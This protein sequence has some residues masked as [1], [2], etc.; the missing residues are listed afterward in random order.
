MFVSSESCVLMIGYVSKNV[1]IF[2]ALLH[3]AVFYVCFFRNL[4]V[5]ERLR[6]Q[7]CIYIPGVIAFLQCC[8][9]LSSL[10]EIGTRACVLLQLIRAGAC[11]CYSS[12]FP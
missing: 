6:Q 11:F 9:F 12:E 7:E 1:Y 5:N 4:C 10:V 3:F 2:Q 8:M